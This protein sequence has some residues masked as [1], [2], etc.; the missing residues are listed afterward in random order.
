MANRKNLR[1]QPIKTHED[2]V[3]KG[4]AG[5][6]KSGE[7]RRKKRDMKE[8]VRLI[9]NLEAPEKVRQ[10][11]I[12]TGLDPTDATVNAQ[13]ISSIVD[14]ATGGDI[15]AA[16]FLRD[17]AGYNAYDQERLKIEREKMKI[18]KQKASGEFEITPEIDES[19]ADD[20]KKPK[21]K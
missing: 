4:R 12:E 15:D 2:A 21:I 14:Q 3:K 8:M 11:L 16:R 7:A 5:G 6:I 18:A 9:L 13:I 1:P 10:A 19:G 17:T 20:E